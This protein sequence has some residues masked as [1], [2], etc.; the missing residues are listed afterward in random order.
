MPRATFAQ[1]YISVVSKMKTRGKKEQKRNYGKLYMQKCRE[2]VEFRDEEKKR[3]EERRKRRK[4]EE[5]MS[6]DRLLLKEEK[7]EELKMSL[8]KAEAPLPERSDDHEDVQAPLEQIGDQPGEASEAEVEIEV[9]SQSKLEAACKSYFDDDA[10][11]HG[12]TSMN[13]GEFNSF[14]EECRPALE[15]TTYRG[16]Q[17]V[18]PN[19]STSISSHSFIFLTLFWLRHYLTIEV[20][21]IL[22]KIDPRSC[23]RIL[24]RTTVAMAKTLQNEIRFP[25]DEEM[26]K[27]QNTEFQNLGFSRCVSVVDGTEISI[28]RPKNSEIQTKTY[29]GKKKQNSLNVMIVTKLDGEIIYHSPLRVGA[30]DQS[31]WNELNL[32]EKFVGKEFGIMGDGGFTFNRIGEEQEIHGYKPYKKPSGGTLTMSEK[33]WNSKLSEVRVVVENSIRVIKTFKILGGIFRH[34]RNGQGQ[35]NGNHVLTICVT[36]ANRRIKRKPLRAPNWKASDH[37]V[38]FDLLAEDPPDPLEEMLYDV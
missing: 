18:L 34:W 32:R 16:T 31:H 38:D 24:K 36:L 1:N 37:V 25:P 13:V 17:R 4:I 28:S 5:R 6:L 3:D 12:L 7:V 19:T 15:M 8:K 20:L 23:T 21:S 26:N 35:I 9:E 22:F 30:H 29:S 14:V 10:A 27:L 2:N 33:E 11:L